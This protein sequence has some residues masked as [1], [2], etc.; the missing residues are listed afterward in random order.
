MRGGLTLKATQSFIKD[1]QRLSPD[2]RQAVDQCLK[3]LE[4]DPIPASRRA[5]S[6]SAKGERPKVFTV[7][8]MSNKSYKLSFSLEGSMAMLR[9]VATHREI[10][11]NGGK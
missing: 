2:I 6:V 4:R 9:R 10:D 1:Y 3:D 5:H 8:V 7:D 11:R